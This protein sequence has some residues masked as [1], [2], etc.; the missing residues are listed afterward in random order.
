MAA[1]IPSAGVGRGSRLRQIVGAHPIGYLFVLPYLIFLAAIYGYPFLFSIYMSFYDYFFA[2]PGADVSRPFVGLRNYVNVLQDPLFHLAMRNIVIFLVINVPLTVVISLV[3][4]TALNGAIPFRSFFRGA[5]FVPYITASVATVGVWYWLASGYGLM[6]GLLGSHA[7]RP[8]F[9]VNAFWAMQMIAYYVTWKGLGFYVL[10]FLAA[11]QNIPRELYEA[12]S[13][14]GA[15]RIRSFLTVTVPGVRP[16]TTLVVILAIITGASIFT[17][18][19]LLTSG[20]G[21]DNQSVSPVFLIYRYGIEQNHPGY[22]S[23]IGV[24]LVIGILAVAAVNRFVL[25]RE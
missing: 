7:P 24:L 3:L 2:A 10:L 14:D 1:A 16:A 20:G 4:A 21:P 19:Y 13:V 6:A 15:G 18:P 25:E 11:L 9:L 12:A 17:E 8:P 22:A 5:Y 23:A